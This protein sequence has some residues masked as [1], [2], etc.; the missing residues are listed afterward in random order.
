M[1]LSCINLALFK[2][3]FLIVINLKFDT[4]SINYFSV[5]LDVDIVILINGGLEFFNLVAHYF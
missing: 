4:K 1:F 2:L 3:F 5:V